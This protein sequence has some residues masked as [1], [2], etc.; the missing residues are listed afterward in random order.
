MAPRSPK[1]GRQS[2]RSCA[3]SVVRRRAWTGSYNGAHRGGASNRPR[4]PE[5]ARPGGRPV[6][7]VSVETLLISL[8]TRRVHTWA[9]QRTAIGRDYVLVR[10]RSDE[11]IEGW[12]E[13]P[14]LKDWG[15]DY[16]RY[17]GESPQTTQVVV[18]DYLAPA[19]E[20]ADPLALEGCYARL[21]QSV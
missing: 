4:S 19:L 1:A 3:A 9:G 17:F 18:R 2:V 6:K 10:V 20:G 16:G 21:Q 8:P 13:A 5:N 7:V 11:G 15:G 12:G 14:V